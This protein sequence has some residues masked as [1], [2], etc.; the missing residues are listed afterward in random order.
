MAHLAGALP[1]PEA[2]AVRRARGSRRPV[3]AAGVPLHFLGPAEVP[4]S[5]LGLVAKNR[6]DRSRNVRE[7]GRIST[8]RHSRGR[9]G[10]GATRV[11]ERWM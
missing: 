10:G 3:A 8:P 11:I 4:L 5:K 1:V 6:R 9:G 2:A 7:R